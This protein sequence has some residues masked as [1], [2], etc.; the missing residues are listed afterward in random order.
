[1]TDDEQNQIKGKM[2]SEHQSE[3]Q[4]FS[5]L[6]NRLDQ[7]ARDL[8]KL[9]IVIRK[10]EK[11]DVNAEGRIRLNF[12]PIYPLEEDIVNTLEEYSECKKRLKR[13]K[14]QLQTYGLKL[15]D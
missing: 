11:P 5:C 3:Q 14:Q 2:L 6:Q 7:M 8:E 9:L 10:G 15:D 4:K 1:M 13:L 12:K